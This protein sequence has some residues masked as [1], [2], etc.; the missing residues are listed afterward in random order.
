MIPLP[1]HHDSPVSD[2]YENTNTNLP[3]GEDICYGGSSD[4]KS[5]IKSPSVPM[6]GNDDL[7]DDSQTG[8]NVTFTPKPQRRA[9]VRARE[10][11]KNSVGT[12]LHGKRKWKHGWNYSD[13]LEEESLPSYIYHNSSEDSVD[14]ASTEVSTS[15][16][17]ST[18]SNSSDDNANELLWDMSPQQY[19]LV[20]N[21]SYTHTH[22]IIPSTSTPGN[23]GPPPGHPFSR[24]R[25]HGTSGEDV[26]RSNAFK[27]NFVENAFIETPTSIPPTS[28]LLDKTRKTVVC[29]RSHHL[30]QEFPYQPRPLELTFLVSAMYPNS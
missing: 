14:T 4:L 23:T 10:A 18:T 22:N 11:I 5:T 26:K 21:A 17:D 7:I 13:Q 19:H 27:E 12:I 20:G 15:D 2:V 6:A 1:K 30:D 8:N 3:T 29:P 28:H 9:A 16:N 25:I 24:R